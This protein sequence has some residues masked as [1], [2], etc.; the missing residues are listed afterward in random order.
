MSDLHLRANKSFVRDL[1]K[2]SYSPPTAEMIEELRTESNN[3]EIDLSKLILS[4]L[5]RFKIKSS[6]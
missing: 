3:N 2:T 6:K 1:S 5:H 4:K